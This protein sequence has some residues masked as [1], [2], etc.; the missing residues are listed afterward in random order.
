MLLLDVV[1]IL[2]ILGLTKVILRR[3][4][5]RSRLSSAAP[6]HS[7]TRRSRSCSTSRRSGPGTSPPPTTSRCATRR[8]RARAHQ[9]PARRLALLVAPALA[10]PR[11]ACASTAWGRSSTWPRRSCSSARSAWA[12]RSRPRRS[13]PT[14]PPRPRVGHLGARRP[15]DRR[16]DHGRRAVARDGRRARR[17]VH[18]RAHASPSASSSAASAT[19]SRPEPRRGGRRLSGEDAARGRRSRRSGSLGGDLG[20]GEDDAR[21]AAAR[22]RRCARRRR[23][24]RPHQA[25]AR[26]DAARRARSTTGA[27]DLGVRR[28]AASARRRSRPGSTCSPSISRLQLAAQR[29]EGALAQLGERADVVPVLA[30][31]RGCGRARRSRAAP[32]TRPWPSRRTGARGSS[33]RSRGSNM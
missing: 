4:R 24:R 19:S 10:D 1:P 33:R 21:R 25:H 15:V 9:L 30:R 32:G 27:F 26:A 20:A 16:A 22:R 18:A 6:A 8:A 29:V 28:A 2:A 11:R 12:S 3:S 5:A 13:T 31:P 14:T 23:A 17:A 7:R